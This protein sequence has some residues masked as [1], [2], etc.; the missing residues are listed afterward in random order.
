[1]D[2]ATGLLLVSKEFDPDLDVEKYRDVIDEMAGELSVELEGISEPKKVVG[3]FARHLFFK[4]K[5]TS[6]KPGFPFH[7][8]TAAQMRRL[9]LL[10]EVLDGKKGHCLGLSQLYVCLAERLGV[11]MYVVDVPTTP[12]TLGHVLVRHFDGEAFL[13]VETTARGVITKTKHYRKTLSRGVKDLPDDFGRVLRSKKQVIAN[14]IGNNCV[15]GSLEPLEKRFRLLDIAVALDPGCTGAFLN[16]AAAGHRAGDLD[17]A[18]ADYDRALELNPGFAEAYTQRGNVRFDK[19]DFKGAAAD[20]TRAIGLAPRVG[21]Y[22]SNRGNCR[23]RL[24]DVKG[25]LADY[26]RAVKLD[27]KNAISRLNR[28]VLHHNTGD[29]KAAIVD[30]D[31]VIELKPTWTTA[32]H[33]RG[34][35]RRASG[36]AEGALRD[37]RKVV[38]LDPGLW[39]VW[40]EIAEICADR[41]EK[42][43][44]LEA[45]RK[46]VKLAPRRKGRLR[47]NSHFSWL[48]DDPD[49]RAIVGE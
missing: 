38:A 24:G 2:I 42:E 31:G 41:R 3:R 37:Y 6:P 15:G 18:I 7:T 43:P 5:F 33:Y 9:C 49:F 35:A 39:N 10:D 45:L 28:A 32:Y 17:G 26:D 1:V 22:Y 23:T 48:R 36:D 34:T 40:L 25:A 13:N 21:V 12:G 4:K 19:K 14:L 44:C 46:V 29:L 47:R 20:H 30:Y 27:P 11:P 16:R 8:L